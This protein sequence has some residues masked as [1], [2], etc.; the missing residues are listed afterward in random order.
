LHHVRP[1]SRNR[2]HL[3]IALVVFCSQ[4][5]LGCSRQQS[6]LAAAVK[7]APIEFVQ[8]WGTRGTEPGQLED[9]VSV[10]IDPIGR[11]YFADRGTGFVEKFETSGIPLLTFEHPSVHNA[12]AIAVDVG[13]GIYV[14]NSR[15]GTM[16]V[17]FPQGEP[18]RALRTA[19]QRNSEGAF[20]FSIDPEGKIYVPD[21]A[22]ARVQV[23]NARGQIL[24]VWRIPPGGSEKAAHPFAAVA[25]NN[26]AVYVGDGADG[27]ILKFS[28]EGVQS[29]LLNAPDSGEA[30]QLLSLAVSGKHL[31]VLRGF[32]PRLEVWNEA[33]LR[34]LVDT[35]GDRLAALKS[36]DALLA[37]NSAGD[38]IVVDRQA[39]RVFRFRAHLDSQ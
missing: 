37:A 24:K 39:R 1:N 10:A 19:P 8:E 38:V 17:F 11:I 15:A 13:G 20:I 9:P 34:E 35:L 23:F 36:A 3:W 22:G 14:A 16:Q 5:A 33:G 2:I 25:D 28:R 4:M 32:P 30:S 12:D 29:A 27:R 26:G 18:L 6:Q 21:S 31:L 7:P